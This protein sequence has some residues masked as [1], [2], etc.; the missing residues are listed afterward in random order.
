MPQ[1]EHK[2]EIPQRHIWKRRFQIFL[3][4]FMRKLVASKI[5]K[6]FVNMTE[7]FPFFVQA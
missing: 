1:I 3:H 6:M 2:T 5:K 4:D 7:R